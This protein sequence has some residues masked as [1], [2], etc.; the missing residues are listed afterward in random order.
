[1]KLSKLIKQSKS[2]DWCPR[3]GRKTW[4]V[5][6]DGYIYGIYS[7]N[8]FSINNFNCFKTKK[9]ATEKLQK[10]KRILK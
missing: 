8:F 4:R 10:I 3:K 2:K 5:I 1:M 9:E 7:E 6:V